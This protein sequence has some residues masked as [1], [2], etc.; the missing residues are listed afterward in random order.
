MEP[1]EMGCFAVGK[2]P[3][4]HSN[5]KPVPSSGGIGRQRGVGGYVRRKR[6][7]RL[8]SGTAQDEPTHDAWFEGSY[9]SPI[10]DRKP[11]T[12]PRWRVEQRKEWHAQTRAENRNKHCRKN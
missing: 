12:V 11:V 1:L 7:H 3:P 4:Q 8:N 10:Q 6:R 2:V 5:L 9:M